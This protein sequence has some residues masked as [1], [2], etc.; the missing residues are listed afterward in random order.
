[1]S[2]EIVQFCRSRRQSRRCTRR[3]GHPGLHRHRSVMWSDAG[4]DASRCSGSGQ[5]GSPAAALPD[6]WP[7]GR[8]MCDRCHDFVELT[9]EGRLVAHD[10]DTRHPDDE[11][12]RR[13][14][15]FNTV[16]W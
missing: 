13:Q 2:D 12:R 9:A 6:A 8:A 11:L 1:M 7:H 3:L 15:W 4:A 16:G 5:A 10:A 14:E